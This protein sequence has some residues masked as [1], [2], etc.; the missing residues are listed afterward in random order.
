MIRIESKRNKFTYNIYH[1]V[2]AFYPG[3]EVEQKVDAQQESLVTLHMPGDSSF[4]VLPEEIGLPVIQDPDERQLQTEKW[5]VTRRVYQYL[6][7]RNKSGLAWGILTGVRPT[8]LIMQKIETGGG[9]EDIL[10]SDRKS[11]V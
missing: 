3:E 7:E 6:A 8:K 9:R 2:K 10:R 5:A 4:S 1:I 11:V